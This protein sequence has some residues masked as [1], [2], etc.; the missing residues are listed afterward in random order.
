MLLNSSIIAHTFMQL[1][2][3]LLCCW[4]D[5]QS[6]FAD[7]SERFVGSH[8]FQQPVAPADSN[9][10]AKINRDPYFYVGTN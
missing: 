3:T 4:Y 1:Y 10:Y 9:F 2:N 5:P 7:V 8:S 6:H